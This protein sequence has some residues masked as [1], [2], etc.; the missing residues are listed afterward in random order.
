AVEKA[1]TTKGWTFP[2]PPEAHSFG[3][4]QEIAHFIECILSNKKP[5][6]DSVYGYKILNIVET[7]YKSAKTKKLEEVV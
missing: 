3:Y 7:M 1:D 2:V 4:P 6:T 5:L